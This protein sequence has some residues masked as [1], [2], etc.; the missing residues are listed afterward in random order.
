MAKI[1]FLGLGT[2]GLPMAHNL[3]KGQ[4]SVTGFDLSSVSLEQHKANGGAVATSSAD[5]V[6]NAD[7]IFTMLPI[8]KHVKAVLADCIDSIKPNTLFIEMSTIHPLET[9]EIR[10]QLASK[11]I[12][13]VDAPVGRTSEHAYTGTLL[14][15]A[16]G[17]KEDLSKAM[18][19]LELLGDPIIDCGGAGTGSRMKVINNFLSNMINVATAEALTLAEVVGLNRDLAIDVMSGTAAGKGHMTTTYPNKVLKNDLTPAFT[20]D[21]AQKDQGLAI[22]LADAMNVD[23]LLGK[24][25]QTIYRQA[26]EEGRGHQD[27]TAVYAMMRAQAGLSD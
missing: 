24:V 17:A 25:T 15:M 19:M 4:H 3:I 12:P 21:F 6:S 8:G 26:Q 9:D 13:M 18:P 27:W 1:A 2:M 14:I 20:L 11:N 10:T 22:D 23:S 7:V 16:G 5:A